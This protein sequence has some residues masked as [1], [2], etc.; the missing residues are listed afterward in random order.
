MPVTPAGD[1]GAAEV[2]G[3]ADAAGCVSEAD[4]V[5]VMPTGE[6]AAVAGATLDAGV[7]ACAVAP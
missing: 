7:D 3:G 1:A 6:M 5:P 2:T 4:A